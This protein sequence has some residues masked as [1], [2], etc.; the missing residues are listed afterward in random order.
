MSAV[1][2]PAGCQLTRCLIDDPAVE[3]DELERIA[4]RISQKSGFTDRPHCDPRAIAVQ[5]FG[6]RLCPWPH[7]RP[8]LERGI[9]WYPSNAKET[10][11]AYFVAHELGHHVLAGEPV[12]EALERACSRIGVALLLPREPFAR[13]VSER[14]DLRAAWPLATGVVI[15]RRMG[16]VSVPQMQTQAP[17]T[18]GGEPIPATLAE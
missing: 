2:P 12:G 15:R 7:A 6:L 9:I 1:D 13:D 5:H 18:A 10:A 4:W 3:A 17:R 16:E 8:R 14:V 11:Q